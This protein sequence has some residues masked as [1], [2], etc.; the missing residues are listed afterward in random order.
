[1]APSSAHQRVIA[2]TVP[3]AVVVVGAAAT[4]TVGAYYAGLF[5]PGRLACVGRYVRECC[6]EAVTSCG[7]TWEARE[8]SA[9]EGGGG[10]QARPRAR[11]FTSLPELLAWAPPPDDASDP[12][13]AACRATTV[14]LSPHVLY[15]IEHGDASRPLLLVCHDMANGYH[16]D[17][18][19]Q[20]TDDAGAFRHWHWASVDI[21]CYFSHATVALPPP[22]W[23]AAAHRS[24]TRVL[25][26]F[27]TEWHD[28]RRR[29]EWMLESTARSQA[30]ADQLV[31]LC[32]YYGFEGWLLNI[33][34][35]LPARLLPAMLHFVAY[36]R[37][38]LRRAVSGGMVIWYD[39]VTTEGWLEWQN[40][41]TH[42]NQ[43]F[44]DAADGV[45]TNYAWSEGMPKTAAASAGARAADV[46]VGTDVW[47]RGTYG[48]GGFEI[49]GALRMCADARV[50]AV[51][52][53]PA[54]P[55][56]CPSIAL[57]TRASPSGVW[58]RGAHA[59]GSGP[60]HNMCA[61]D[62]QPLAAAALC[63]VPA[64]LALC[65]SSDAAFCGGGCLDVAGRLPLAPSGAAA[66]AAAA[67]FGA[68]ASRAAAVGAASGKA[69]GAAPGAVSR[70][71]VGAASRASPTG[72]APAT[73]EGGA[74]P[75]E[76]LWLRYVHVCDADIDLAPHLA[77]ALSTHMHAGVTERGGAGAD[78]QSP[79][80]TAVLTARFAT[81]EVLAG[82]C[83]G[84]ALLVRTDSTGTGAGAGGLA[85]AG[86]P[87]G[88]TALL[89]L[90]RGGQ[91]GAVLPPGVRCLEAELEEECATGAVGGGGGHD[92]DTMAPALQAPWRLWACRVPASAL[93]FPTR[94][95]GGGPP[96]VVGIGVMCWAQPEVAVGAS[97]RRTT[98][99][100]AARYHALLGHISLLPGSHP[101]ECDQ[102]ECGPPTALNVRVSPGKDMVSCDLVWGNHTSQ[103]HGAHPPHRGHHVWA[104]ALGA[105][106]A[107]AAVAAAA[108]SA[109]EQQPK[110]EG[111]LEGSGGSG[112]GSS[113]GAPPPTSHSTATP[114][115]PGWVAIGARCWDGWVG[116][117]ATGTA[118]AGRENMD[119]QAQAQATAEVQHSQAPAAEASAAAA[120]AA[121]AAAPTAAVPAAAALP[122]HR[123]SYLGC[124]ASRVWCV[125]GL[126]LPPGAA[127]VRFSVQP[128]SA[129]HGLPANGAPNEGAAGCSVTV[130]L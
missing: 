6:A 90:P 99:S 47:G 81:C 77:A 123:A 112:S 51:L 10:D 116:S 43:P 120:A 121:A 32:V 96:P 84:L 111:S 34:N 1:M 39:A 49:G 29:C 78:R 104:T 50:S 14:P 24:G 91:P 59:E 40:G 61:S 66:A 101:L 4:A 119:E 13:A 30:V 92:G 60:W 122:L 35:T 42:L 31:A 80:A 45:F 52:F 68:A 85:P 3:T 23:I 56:H 57:P 94:G 26:T 107:G 118:G 62:L 17:A 89:L 9:P 58:L 22:T 126:R 130:R 69:S 128:V 86:L 55:Q 38:S 83:L 63:D 110:R 33:E 20:G 109:Q 15:E 125:R 82:S 79:V 27:I 21:F 67:T 97:S 72:A 87:P 7:L 88:C 2:V 100:M 108:T 115:S 5:S 64:P 18:D 74:G 93:H 12:A 114:Q 75:E 25:G 54:L 41:L 16:D 28:G 103:G 48:G 37:A 117:N 124:C 106:A 70:A 73:A 102:L 65:F 76:L 105:T 53:A 98:V 8:E 127:G 71:A 19:P 11:P 113:D 44:F 95:G 36:L 46:F 129:A